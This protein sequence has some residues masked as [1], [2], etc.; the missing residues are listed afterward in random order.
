MPEFVLNTPI[1][2]DG[3]AIEVTVDPQNPLPVG[4][5]R[6]RLTVTDDSGNVSTPDEV[7]VI[8][9]DT[10]NPT[11]ILDPLQTNPEY[12]TSFTLSGKRSS[13]VA[14]GKIVSYEWT[15]V[16]APE[17]PVIIDGPVIIGRPIVLGDG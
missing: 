16:P 13:D 1:Q 14:P 15:M 10:K 4:R 9:R 5:H 8:V 6:F 2:T 17:R 12:G 7:D 3:A 11:A